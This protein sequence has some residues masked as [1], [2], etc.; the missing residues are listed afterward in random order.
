MNLSAAK[1]LRLAAI[2]A[3]LLCF[4]LNVDAGADAAGRLARYEAAISSGDPAAAMDFLQDGEA[5]GLAE[6][7]MQKAAELT[8][9]AEA[10]KDLK[11]LL[12]MPWKAAEA[13]KLNQSLAIRI[14]IDKPLSKAG[15]GPE[16]EKLLAWLGKYLPA[17]PAGKKD[18]VKKAI[19]QWDIVFGTMTDTRGMDWAQATQQYGQGVNLTR[20]NWEGMTLRE[21]NTILNT[22]MDTEPA[23]LT[24]NDEKLAS[25]KDQV[26]VMKTVNEVKN[27]G[28]LSASQLGQLAGKSFAD[29]VYLLGSFFDGS[30]VA[31]SA[32]LKAK[33][34]AARDSMPK[35]V[36]PAQQRDLLG[37]MLTSAVAKELAG[38]TAGDRAL[39][40]GPLKIEVR[41]CDGS[42]SRYD[43]AS[44]A[45]VLDSETIQQ[46]MRMKG[47]TAESVMKSREQVAEIAKYMSPSVVY[48]AAHKMQ[49]DW[50]AKQGVYKPHVQ[51]DEIEAMS[52]EGVYTNEKMR[53]DPAFK[54]M[55][56]SGRQFSSYASKKSEIATNYRGSRAKGFSQTVRKFYVPGLPSLD[57]AAAQVRS[58]ISGELARR[59]GLPPAEKAELDSSGLTLNDALEMSPE[60]LAGSVQEIQTA[61]LAKIGRDLQDLAAYRGRYE[62]S[63][64]ATRGTLT[65]STAPAGKKSAP[66][67]L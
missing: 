29:Q 42:Y 30:N 40:A 55:L 24:Y 31:V 14:D 33:V 47:Y 61:A 58:A 49:A 8:A 25:M 28:A 23:F 41:P 22:L 66:P 32:D 7:D 67:A 1:T 21:R 11:E 18:A 16:P 51:E 48:E 19:R 54:G 63:E 26:A 57:G 3:G 39:A 56:D 20:A 64:T 17:Y 2:T 27:S 52:L 62:A 9:E 59:A 46:Y 34:N 37:G 53:Q 50:A 60:E 35:E 15:V 5:R 6:K 43:A 12:A 38:T 36:L 4:G 10:L 65:S 45:I 13:N 44:G